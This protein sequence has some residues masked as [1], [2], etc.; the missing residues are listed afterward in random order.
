MKYLHTAHTIIEILL[1]AGIFTIECKLI[2]L[3]IS[4]KAKTTSSTVL[5]K[6]SRVEHH[7]ESHVMENLCIFWKYRNF[8]KCLNTI[9][10]I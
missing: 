10:N 6:F 7:V 9:L 4:L 5:K 1:Q 8:T 3:Q 2:N